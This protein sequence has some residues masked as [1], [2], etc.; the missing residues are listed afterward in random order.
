MDIFH[1]IILILIA[2]IFGGIGQSVAG[3]NLSG[4]FL[5]IVVGLI[6]A[7]VGPM[8]AAYNEL[9]PIF[10]ISIMDK[11]YEMFWSMVGALVLSFIVG[12]FRRMSGARR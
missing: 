1:L 3:Y 8:V 2:A 9:D 6:G 12:L 10:K 11:E 5:G 4:C 7:I